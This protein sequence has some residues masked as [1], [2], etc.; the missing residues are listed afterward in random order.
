[1]IGQFYAWLSDEQHAEARGGAITLAPGDAGLVWLTNRPVALVPATLGPAH[2]G[3]HRYRV[4]IDRAKIHPWT[5]WREKQKIDIN[6]YFHLE[7]AERARPE[8]WWIS[9]LPVVA[10]HDPQ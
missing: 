3:P 10:T 8:F 2:R 7:V 9:P 4:D 1:M 5:R 6:D